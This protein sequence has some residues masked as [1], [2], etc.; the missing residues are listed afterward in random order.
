[1]AD[2]TFSGP[3]FTPEGDQILTGG[4]VSAR[5]AVAARGVEL[6]VGAFDN[7]IRVNR[8]Q[9]TS[10]ITTTDESR[11]YTSEGNHGSYTMDIDVPGNSTA[12]TTSNAKYG[13]WLSGTGSRNATTSFKGYPAFDEA[14]SQ[15]DDQ[16]GDVAREALAPYIDKLNG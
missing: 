13:P 6:A 7:H 8:H 2:V 16:A 10:T 9:H 1:M 11:S 4:I 3:F 12:V 5:H 14:A 15:L